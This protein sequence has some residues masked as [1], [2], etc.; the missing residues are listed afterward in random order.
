MRA[1]IIPSDKVVTIDGFSLSGIDM[2]GIDQSVH[3]VQWYDTFGEV[4]I[5]G[6]NGR[7]ISNELI[8]SLSEYQSI[9]EQFF[10]AKSIIDAAAEL[11]A[12]EQTI[13]EV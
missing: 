6:A 2:T 12:E 9:L 8:D 13:I 10:T 7:M 1:T 11:A 5:I 4:E 3:A